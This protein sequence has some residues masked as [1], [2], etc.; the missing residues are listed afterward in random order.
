MRR[1][2]FGAGG[3][4]GPILNIVSPVSGL[5]FGLGS[6]ANI[7]SFVGTAADDIAPLD[8]S[9][10][11]EW[12]VQ[13]PG[14]PSLT[15][16]GS[17]TLATGASVDLSAALVGPGSPQGSP[18]GANAFTVVARSTDAGGNVATKSITLTVITD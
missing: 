11:I 15:T 4:K 5:T 6:P 17:P 8:I 7:P 3:F 16:F 12:I 10:S 2:R 1:G 13:G 14:S 9:S 18:G